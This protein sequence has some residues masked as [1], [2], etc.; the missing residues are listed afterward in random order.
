MS[1]LSYT[2]NKY[3]INPNNYSGSNYQLALNISRINAEHSSKA[4]TIASKSSY[5]GYGISS[6]DSS[7]SI[8]ASSSGSHMSHCYFGNHSSNYVT[9]TRG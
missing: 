9:I 5:Y 6:S 4:S 2:N 3:Q 1:S 8:Q 7:D